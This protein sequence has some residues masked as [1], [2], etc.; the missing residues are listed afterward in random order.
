M[1]DE[2]Q[3]VQIRWNNTNRDW[4][5]SKGY[6]YTKRNE[7]FDVKAK[8]LKPGSRCRITVVCDYCG[9]EYITQNNVLIAG[10]EKYL[11]DCCPCC[12]GSKA[13]DINRAKRGR[14]Y[15]D[16]LRNVC[17]DFGYELITPE[18]MFT[19]V[20]MKI[21]YR[22]PKHGIRESILDNLLHRHGCLECSYETRFDS[23]RHDQSYIEAIINHIDENTW[24]NPG[25]YKEAHVRNLRIRCKCGNEYVT[26]F[27][28]FLKR[29]VTQ[30]FSCSC[31]E[32][33]GEAIV[34]RFLQD[35]DI[36]F[37]PEKRFNDCRDKKPLPFDFFLPDMNVCIEFDGKQH[38]E[39]LD[40]F[41]DFESVQRH[42]RIKNQYCEDHHIKLIRIPYYSGSK[43]AEILE[44]E[45]TV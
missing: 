17:D 2:E 10:R 6:T 16:R 32:S 39:E 20:H 36:E 44:K 35:H 21:Q 22:C 28:N 3:V 9:N 27:Q 40:G 8:D 25:E 19:N 41:S 37:I 34:R 13:W 14:D 33:K 18:D 11:K 43:I 45:L 24:L 29:G 42:D 26:S 38:F 12:V 23:V 4:Y 7:F 30:C 31:K 1:Y 15:F 5:E